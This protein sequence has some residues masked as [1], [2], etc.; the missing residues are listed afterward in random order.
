VI[1]LI[2]W[3][4]VSSRADYSIRFVGYTVIISG[5]SADA[6]IT[7]AVEYTITTKIIYI[8]AT[9]SLATSFS[10]EQVPPSGLTNSF[11]GTVF[12]GMPI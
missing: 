2:A 6:R 9:A 3:P 7:T 12:I 11:G 8:S 1:I 10:L 5:I 4:V